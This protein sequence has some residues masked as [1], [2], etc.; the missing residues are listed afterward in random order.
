MQALL[1]L[2][3]QRDLKV[4]AECGDGLDAL[5]KAVATRPDVILRDWIP[6]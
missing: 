4:I 6:S 1:S 5:S 3:R 2:D